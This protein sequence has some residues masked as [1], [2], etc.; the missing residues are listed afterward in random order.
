VATPLLK[1]RQHVLKPRV[2]LDI[3]VKLEPLLS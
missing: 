1:R 2:S 3:T